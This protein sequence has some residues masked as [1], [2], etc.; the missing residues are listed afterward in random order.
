MTRLINGQF[1]QAIRNEYRLDWHGVHGVGHW[2][3]VRANG[4]SISAANGANKLIVEYFAFLHDVCRQTNT[5]DNG[6]G[7]RAALF[8]KSIRKDLIKLSDEEFDLLIVAL[9]DHNE[10]SKNNNITVRTCWDADRLDLIRI[11]ITPDSVR[12]CTEVGKQ[13]AHLRGF[14]QPMNS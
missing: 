1:V 10:K 3:R 12:L 2:S 9:E 4:L 5:L 7:K 13:L 8:A 14:I 6:H 11:G